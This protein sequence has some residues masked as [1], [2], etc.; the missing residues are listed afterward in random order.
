MNR[1]FE[2]PSH[3][4]ISSYG[5][6]G[7]LIET[8]K[9]S[10]VVLPLEKWPYYNYEIKGTDREYLE[11]V[12]VNDPRLIQRLCSV[13]KELSYLLKIPVNATS[14]GGTQVKITNNLISAEYFPK[15]MFCPSCNRF[16]KY[17][18]WNKRFQMARLGKQFDLYCPDCRTPRAGRKSQHILLEQVRFIRISEDGRMEDFPWEE[19]FA[20]KAT[21]ADKCDRHE[22]C[23]R[24]SS[25]SDNLESI[26][27]NCKKCNSSASLIGIFGEFLGGEAMH[28]V[29]KSSSSVYFPSIVRSLMIPL[30]GSTHTTEPCSEMKYRCQELEYMKAKAWEDDYDDNDMINLKQLPPMNRDIALV[31]IRSLSMSSVLCSYS[32]LQPIPSGVFFVPSK[33]RHVTEERLN[34]KY[35]PCIELTGEGFLLIF[36]DLPIQTLYT[37]I[38]LNQQFSARLIDHKGELASYD[39]LGLSGGSDY[40]LYKYVLLHT[41]SHLIIKQLEYVC[42]YP[43][44]SLNERIYCSPAHHAAIMVYT[45]AGY[46]KSRW[47]YAYNI[48]DHWHRTLPY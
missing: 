24:S 26:R 18:D 20:H 9:G 25:Y 19:W 34:T 16:M 31:S 10:L 17:E 4:I 37:E 21:N 29:L 35:L 7:S 11:S 41:I 38:R 13:F 6:I 28:T 47:T 40:A 5:G 32:R 3:S 48:L 1:Y 14:G 27:M 39:P 36:E 33:S 22:F 42:G 2:I 23:Y 43:A 30:S 46:M 44:A 8:P 15:W 12:S 45:V